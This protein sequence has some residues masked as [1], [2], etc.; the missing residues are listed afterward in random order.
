M[1]GSKIIDVSPS[2]REKL[3]YD[4]MERDYR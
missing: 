3:K 2:R 1:R 4:E